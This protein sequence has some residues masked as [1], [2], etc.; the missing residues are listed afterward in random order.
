MSN[1]SFI[2]T[3]G[4]KMVFVY[5]MKGARR[6]NYGEFKDL[7]DLLEYTFGDSDFSDE[8]KLSSFHFLY[9][10]SNSEAVVLQRGYESNVIDTL[11]K[12]FEMG[13]I[14]EAELECNKAAVA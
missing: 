13:L 2:K 10:A 12:A 14:D 5:R 3:K 11:E 1:N 4:D 9:N 8:L 6:A 7:Q